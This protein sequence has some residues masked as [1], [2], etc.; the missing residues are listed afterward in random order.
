[1]SRIEIAQSL[2]GIGFASC[3]IGLVTL[4]TMTSEAVST[5]RVL[6]KRLLLL[7]ITTFVVSLLCFVSSICLAMFEAHENPVR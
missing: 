5:S 6:W 2:L 7:V 1:M 4:L 3:V